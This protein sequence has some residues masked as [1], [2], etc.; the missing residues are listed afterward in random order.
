MGSALVILEYAMKRPSAGLFDILFVCYGS[1]ETQNIESGRPEKVA[2]C[3]R[4]N[5]FEHL[6]KMRQSRQAT[7]G[8]SFLRH[9]QRPW[10]IETKDKEDKKR[11]SFLFFCFEN[12]HYVQ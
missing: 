1:S 5:H 2:S 4:I 7:Y 8:L 6:F 3:P 12:V 10:D 11:L 9:L